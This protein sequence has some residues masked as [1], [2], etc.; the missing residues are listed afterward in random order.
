MKTYRF[1]LLSLLLLALS[2][3][4]FGA[5]AQTA[6]SCTQGLTSALIVVQS[7]QTAT[8]AGNYTQALEDN[9]VAAGELTSAEAICATALGTN[10]QAQDAVLDEDGLALNDNNEA[11]VANTLKNQGLAQAAQFDEINTIE[12][13][14]SDADGY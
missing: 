3:I 5:A 12:K 11:T 14:I 2:A 9:V 13:A 1:A 7:A 10:L 4:S 8:N 6:G